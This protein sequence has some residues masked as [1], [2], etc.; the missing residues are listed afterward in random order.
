MQISEAKNRQHRRAAERLIRALA[1]AK[2]TGVQRSICLLILKRTLEGGRQEACIT[3]KEFAAYADSGTAYISKQLKKLLAWHV[4]VRTGEIG[5]PCVYRFNDNVEA[6]FCGAGGAAPAAAGEKEQGLL[7]GAGAGAKER[8][9]LPGAA[10]GEKEQ[11]LSSNAAAGERKRRSVPAAAGAE[12]PKLPLD[13]AAGKKLHGFIGASA[14]KKVQGLQPAA[15]GANAR[16]PPAAGQM[17]Q[18]AGAAANCADVNK[19]V[20]NKNKYINH[21][22]P[23]NDDDADNNDLTLIAQTYRQEFGREL[24]PAERQKLAYYQNQGLSEEIICE[25]LKRARQQGQLKL[26]YAVGIL[27]NWLAKGIT[28][29]GGVMQADIE[30]KKRAQLRAPAYREANR[31]EGADRQ[32]DKYDSIIPVYCDES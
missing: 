6:W 2:L 21:H 4:I 10:G 1:C 13:T 31:Y 8:G 3:L 19:Q 24:S 14:G 29:I 23:I 20:I 32:A 7:P 17:R 5:K 16:V 11:G 25:A 9:L 27:N 15:A 28:D 12:V 26:C 22:Q 30:F 18:R